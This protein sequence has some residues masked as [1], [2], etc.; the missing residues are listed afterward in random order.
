MKAKYNYFS[1]VYYFIWRRSIFL[2]AF[3]R[4]QLHKDE[5]FQASSPK[6]LKAGP[7]GSASFFALCPS[8]GG[9]DLQTSAG[10]AL[11]AA[12]LPSVPVIPAEGGIPPASDLLTKRGG[13]RRPG[14]FPP[15]RE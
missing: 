1:M 2:L 8:C 5:A 11:T 4:S 12:R 15:S 10:M 6:T 14:G 7:S 13:T 3:A 9:D